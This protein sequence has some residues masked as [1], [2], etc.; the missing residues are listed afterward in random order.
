M[1]SSGELPESRTSPQVLLGSGEPSDHRP[2]CRTDN[3]LELEENGLDHAIS[4]K[5]DS[6]DNLSNNQETYLKVQPFA[7]RRQPHLAEHAFRPREKMSD[8][9][10]KSGRIYLVHTSI[11]GYNGC[12]YQCTDRVEVK[13]RL[14]LT[15]CRQCRGL[16]P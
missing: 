1:S 14:F 16:R 4:S 12:V 9:R 5:K 7:K 8:L 15:V 3:N 2:R 10:W 6:G 13:K 11:G